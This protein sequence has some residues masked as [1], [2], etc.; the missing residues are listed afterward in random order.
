ME[1][2]CQYCN[3]RFNAVTYKQKYCSRSCKNCSHSSARMER[4][5]THKLLKKSGYYAT[6]AGKGEVERGDHD[7]TLK[8]NGITRKDW[9]ENL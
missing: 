7:K 5:D 6:F 8:E 4:N 9:L 2:I 1:K 3:K